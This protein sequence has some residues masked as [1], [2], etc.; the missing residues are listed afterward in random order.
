VTQVLV[1]CARQPSIVAIIFL[2]TADTQSLDRSDALQKVGPIPSFI[3]FMR[4]P[5]QGV[6]WR[7]TNISPNPP[8]VPITPVGAGLHGQINDRRY[9]ELE[10][11][12]HRDEGEGYYLN[13]ESPEP[14]IFVKWRLKEAAAGE[15]GAPEAI[16]ISLSY[17][18][19]GRWLDAGEPVDRVLMPAE[20]LPWLAEFTQLH[21]EPEGKKKK[22]GPKP[23]FMT[24]SE[25]S[26]M[27]T[28]EINIHRNNQQ[29]SNQDSN[30]KGD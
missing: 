20:M 8:N 6:G 10:L 2:M 16:A 30:Q 26:D 9:V 14:S 15:I 3:E 11:W 27:T 5:N 23:S 28:R 4:T 19:A 21:Y 29:N 24:R 17:N 7:L 25:F 12:V 13:L 18:E 1:P 22:R